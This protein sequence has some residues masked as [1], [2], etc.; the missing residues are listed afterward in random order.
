M[1]REC[2][3]PVATLLLALFIAT[4]AFAN[5]LTDYLVSSSVT[6]GNRETYPLPTA[7]S[8]EEGAGIC[9]L[10]NTDA[11]LTRISNAGYKW[12]RLDCDWNTIEPVVGA[13]Y[14]WSFFD[15]LVNSLTS[16]GF[17]LMMILHTSQPKYGAFPIDTPEEITGYTNFAAAVVNR[18]RNKGILWELW[19]EPHVSTY[20]HGTPNPTKYMAMVNS[21]VQAIRAQN[22]DEW[23][24]GA[25]TGLLNLDFFRACVSLGLLNCVDAVTVH[26]YNGTFPEANAPYFD[27]LRLYIEQNAPA[28]KSIPIFVS[29]DGVNNATAS[30]L[31]T[32]YAQREPLFNLV[33]GISLTCWFNYCDITDLNLNLTLTFSHT[34]NCHPNS[35]PNPNPNP[36]SNC[37]YVKKTPFRT[38]L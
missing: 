38:L 1:F 28:G 9:Q 26:P 35:S 33:Q 23:L 4:V 3:R 30:D 14:Q 11:D 8:L 19:N 6:M 15:N 37:I 29:E 24:V 36:N 25:S 16:R 10:K 34:L 27:A 7:T 13:G 5:S 17:R 2:I 32:Q 21:T 31:R 12:I 22:P 20:W 18:Y